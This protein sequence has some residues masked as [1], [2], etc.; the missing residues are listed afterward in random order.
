[1]PETRP[2]HLASRE[3][4]PFR[5]VDAARGWLSSLD[6]CRVGRACL[7]VARTV[8]ANPVRMQHGHCVDARPSPKGTRAMNFIRRWRHRPERD[9]EQLLVKLWTINTLDADEHTQPGHLTPK[10]ALAAKAELKSSL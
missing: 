3:N 1:M 2:V 7:P 4:L 9:Q 8:Q 6:Q 5:T 10:L